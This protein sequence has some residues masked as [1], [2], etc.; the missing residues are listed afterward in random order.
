MHAAR[1]FSLFRLSLVSLSSIPR[2]NAMKHG[3][4]SCISVVSYIFRLLRV[5]RKKKITYTRRRCWMWKKKTQVDPC[6]LKTDNNFLRYCL[7]TSLLLCVFY[8]FFYFTVVA[9]VCD[10]A[11]IYS[12]VFCMSLLDKMRRC[13]ILAVNIHLKRRKKRTNEPTNQYI[14]KRRVERIFAAQP[15]R[16]LF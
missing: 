8:I 9:I 1:R 6:V 15:H 2:T 14:M 16:I 4:A 13:H 5:K 3:W 11:R 7:L 10:A 12:Q